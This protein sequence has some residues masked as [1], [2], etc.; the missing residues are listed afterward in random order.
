MQEGV[1]LALRDALVNVEEGS[2]LVWLLSSELPTVDA[3]D[4]DDYFREAT[5]LAANAARECLALAFAPLAGLAEMTQNAALSVRLASSVTIAL[6]DRVDFGNET[7]RPITDASDVACQLLGSQVNER[8]VFQLLSVLKDGLAAAISA[9]EGEEWLE[10]YAGLR[11]EWLFKETSRIIGT[12]SMDMDAARKL[13][14]LL[15][16]TNRAAESR[17][18]GHSH[19]AS[20]IVSE[21][22]L[23]IPFPFLTSEPLQKNPVLYPIERESDSQAILVSLAALARTNL[24]RWSIAGEEAEE[25]FF[26]PY[27]WDFV[28]IVGENEIDAA[29]ALRL[30]DGEEVKLESDGVRIIV[31]RV[32][33]FGSRTTA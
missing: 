10:L 7:E 12:D 1:S 18:A 26:D 8:E 28:D 25:P 33:D 19:A 29:K 11:V 15:G 20:E 4:K 24:D 32:S 23:S 6:C 16:E 21:G 22:R 31:S 2:A 13:V 27:S 9:L 5:A 30:Q 17:T 3:T 14:K